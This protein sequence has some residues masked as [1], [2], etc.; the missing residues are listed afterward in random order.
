M[1][2]SK[3]EEIL[4]QSSKISRESLEQVL[5]NGHLHLTTNVVNEI[6]DLI[7]QNKALIE[8]MRSLREYR[9]DVTLLIQ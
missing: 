9:E 4:D 7:H 6:R 3:I 5:M 1:I 8:T 2:E